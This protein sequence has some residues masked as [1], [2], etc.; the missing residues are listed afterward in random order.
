MKS[1]IL[2]IMLAATC[3][4][5][6]TN[7]TESVP[8]VSR[9]TMYEVTTTNDIPRWT[10]QE[11]LADGY[12]WTMYID[13]LKPTHPMNATGGNNTSE[14]VRVVTKKRVCTLSFRW[15]GKIR[16]IVDEE[17]LLETRTLLK[18]REIWEEQK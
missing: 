10:P 8:P 18:R 4:L 17:I 14:R 11:C 13:E 16:E 7:L 6:N 3:T 15:L 1:T 5:A 2:L 12:A 9:E